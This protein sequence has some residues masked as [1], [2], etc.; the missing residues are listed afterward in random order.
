MSR[1]QHVQLFDLSIDC[2]YDNTFIF[3]FSVV[4][5]SCLH[6]ALVSTRENCVKLFITSVISQ[7]LRKSP[8]FFQNN[9]NNISTVMSLYPYFPYLPLI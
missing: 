4:P 8:S 3:M 2:F 1:I 7:I 5:V 9:P 6:G